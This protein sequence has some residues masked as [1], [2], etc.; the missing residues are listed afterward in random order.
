MDSGILFQ[1]FFCG[2]KPRSHGFLSVDENTGIPKGMSQ[3]YWDERQRQKL[4]TGW[5]REGKLHL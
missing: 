4:I 2:G 3:R 1:M 5:S